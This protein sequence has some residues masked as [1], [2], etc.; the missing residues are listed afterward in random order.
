MR[1][2]EVTLAL[3][4]C[5]LAGAVY[6]ERQASQQVADLALEI[7]ELREAVKRGPGPVVLS[8]E[9]HLIMQQLLGPQRTVLPL[10]AQPAPAPISAKA[11]ER[12]KPQ[13]TTVEQRAAAGE[14]SLAIDSAISSGT[15]R[16]GDL[17]K[18]AGLP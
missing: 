14:A 9:E 18:I 11:V 1:W 17:R 4:A 15:V 5:I 10:P 3:S 6:E 8:G 13:Q 7:R 12:E 16:P 2:V